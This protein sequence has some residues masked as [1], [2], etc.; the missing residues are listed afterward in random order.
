MHTVEPGPDRDRNRL[1]TP[2]ALSLVR[3]QHDPLDVIRAPPRADVS[4]D[5]WHAP[6][7]I[8]LFHP[9]PNDVGRIVR[10][11]GEIELAV[12]EQKETVKTECERCQRTNFLAHDHRGQLLA[13]RPRAAKRRVE[14][15]SH[16]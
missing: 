10:W 11:V 2:E 4:P 5:D 14:P 7:E 15:E 16:R 6:S 13:R 12:G 9:D 3:P 1:P 8:R